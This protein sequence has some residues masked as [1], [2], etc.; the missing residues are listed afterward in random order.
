MANLSQL[1]NKTNSPSMFNEG[2]FHHR[3]SI[4]LFPSL[5]L[6]TPPSLAPAMAFSAP[7]YPS[8]TLF[9]GGLPAAGCL[10]AL[11][12]SFCCFSVQSVVVLFVCFEA[13][14]CSVHPAPLIF[15][16]QC[17]MYSFGS[18]LDV[19]LFARLPSLVCVV[20]ARTLCATAL[21]FSHLKIR[22]VNNIDSP[23]LSLEDHTPRHVYRDQLS[24]P[25]K[26]DSNG[27]LCPNDRV[28][29]HLRKIIKNIFITYL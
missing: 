27:N 3:R 12:R 15:Y 22:L 11:E 6:S 21:F 5:Y 4:N 9:A 14:A 13:C 10:A 7:F 29:A 1:L 19:R 24:T 28:I 20:Q 2:L 25:Q 16:L 17:V 18:L 23:P 8:V 26:D